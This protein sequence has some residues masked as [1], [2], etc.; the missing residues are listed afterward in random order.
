MYTH[1]MYTPREDVAD[2]A[3]ALVGPFSYSTIKT[4]FLKCCCYISFCLV[5]LCDSS[6]PFRLRREGEVVNI[7]YE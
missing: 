7:I 4:S 1:N 6:A 5:C 3:R 2:D